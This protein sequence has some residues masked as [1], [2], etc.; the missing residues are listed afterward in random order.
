MERNLQLLALCLKI[1]T[2]LFKQVGIAL[3]RVRFTDLLKLLDERTQLVQH[4]ICLEYHG[5]QHFD[6]F[7]YIKRLL[8][9]LLLQSRLGT[10]RLR[11]GIIILLR[12]QQSIFNG[13]FAKIH[14]IDGL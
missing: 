6:R 3:L 7:T 10:H 11:I 8:V 2:I 5:L 4:G 9:G 1:C 14:H 13:T 12:V